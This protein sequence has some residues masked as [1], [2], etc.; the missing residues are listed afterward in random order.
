MDKVNKV[1]LV[2]LGILL[3]YAVVA[4]YYRVF[5]AR[6]YQ[7]VAEIE[8]D[9]ETESCFVWEDE[10]GE[11]SYYKL[12]TRIAANAP[13]CDIENESCS[14][15]CGDKELDCAYIYCSK[16]SYDSACSDENR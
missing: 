7:V 1:L 9:P 11:V 13:A 8:C 3:V 4:T 6:D 10:N 14:F 12:I 5:V 2:A 15:E 16:N